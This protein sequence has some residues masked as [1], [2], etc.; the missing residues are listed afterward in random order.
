[1]TGPSVPGWSDYCVWLAIG[2]VSL[3]QR[4]CTV[5]TVCA[6]LEATSA[7]WTPE[8]MGAAL[9]FVSLAYLEACTPRTTYT[10]SIFAVVFWF[11]LC[12]L[13]RLGR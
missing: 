9:Y 2:D 4:L 6:V 3:P 1:M 12:A 10:T 13:C 5:S 7:E 8:G 11:A